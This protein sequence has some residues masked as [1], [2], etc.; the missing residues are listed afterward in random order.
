MD[1]D[2]R[3]ELVHQMQQ[4]VYE[5]APYLVTAYDTI[6]EAFR[7]DRFACLVQQPNPGGVWL[8]QYGVYNYLHMRPVSEAGDC[9]GDSSATQATTAGASSSISTGVLVGIGAAVVVVLLAGGVLLLRRRS[10]VADR[11]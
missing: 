9:G 1:K 2:K 4:M 8:F 7:S 5:D 3:V 6:G 11:E 10:T